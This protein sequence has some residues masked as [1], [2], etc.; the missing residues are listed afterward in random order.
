MT[1]KKETYGLLLTAYTDGRRISISLRNCAIYHGIVF[2]FVNSELAILNIAPVDTPRIR[3]V[4]V[5]IDE[6]VTVEI[7]G[8]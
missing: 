1:V 8:K 7:I 3:K 2:G 5:A 6:I 4:Y